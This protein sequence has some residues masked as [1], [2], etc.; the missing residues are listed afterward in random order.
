MSMTPFP[1]SFF[2]TVLLLLVIAFLLYSRGIDNGFVYDDA[3]QILE[4]PWV[5]SWT[6]LP[7]IFTSGVW[8]FLDFLSYGSGYYRPLM[9]VFF[10]LEYHIFG[11]NPVGYHVVSI[12]MHGINA[13][14]LFLL[15]FTFLR[16]RALVLPEYMTKRGYWF[17]LVTALL[18]L[19]HPVNSE[20]VYWASAAPELLLA[21][22][23]LLTLG[24]FLFC[25]P[26]I[27]RIGVVSVFF[28]LALLSKE[29]AVMLP[30]VLFFLHLFL[31]TD[32]PRS[33]FQRFKS[34]LLATGPFFIIATFFLIVR[35]MVMTPSLIDESPDWSMWFSVT[36]STSLQIFLGNIALL[37]RLEPLSLFRDYQPSYVT[38][39]LA[40][41]IVL[42]GLV[43]G[44][45]YWLWKTRRSLPQLFVLGAVPLCL[46]LLPALN[47]FQLGGY[48]LSERYLYVPSFGF[49]I[50]CTT[51]LFWLLERSSTLFLKRCSI[52]ILA[53]I[54]V[55][56]ARDIQARASDW[57]DTTTILNAAVELYPESIEAH[58]PL[59]QV[60]C[61]L[62]IDR[63]QHVYTMFCYKHLYRNPS[64][65]QEEC[66][67]RPRMLHFLARTYLDAG[68]W[69]QAEEYYNQL[70]VKKPQL[71]E[72]WWGLG[73]VVLERREFVRAEEYLFKA[74]ELSPESRSVDLS[75][76]RLFC[77]QGDYERAKH[78]LTEAKQHWANSEALSKAWADCSS[79]DPGAKSSRLDGRGTSP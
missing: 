23:S 31:D 68:Q 11:L 2:P 52:L 26:S 62:D 58:Y 3:L 63:C 14:L 8:D 59:F 57:Q 78:S 69:Q 34:T 21:F 29:T 48:V 16:R 28:T 33:I 72:A 1:K 56:C 64:S 39:Y 38:F 46:F 73:V 7:T 71:G 44:L 79:L 42:G 32:Q 74:K 13:S 50:L 10:T 35:S 18:F 61:Q 41:T 24:C 54:V 30:L 75:L 49:A 37:L 12:L 45:G 25:K 20:V 9:H 51:A 40:L 76:V 43:V 22:F 60:L 77:L 15:V 6:Y 53:G 65:N 4:N 19:A 55:W 70:V 66:F 36:L 27:V 67:Q 5:G 47:Y 17:S